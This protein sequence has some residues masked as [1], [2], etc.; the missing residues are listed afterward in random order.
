MCAAVHGRR[1]YRFVWGEGNPNGRIAVILDNPGARE[2]AAGLPYVCWTRQ[3]L[4]RALGEAG[5][6]EAEVYVAFL[7]KCRPMGKYDRIAAAEL[8]LPLL[9]R[10]LA[11]RP[12]LCL[13][14][15]GDT[16]CKAIYGLEASAKS[17]RGTWLEWDRVPLR[18]SYHPLAARRRPNLFPLLVEDLS[19]AMEMTISP[20]T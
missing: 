14:A 7:F 2:D 4:R 17:L 13:I 5:I 10:Q 8:H 11:E 20:P 3:T 19:A 12:R 18:A 1:P 6:P 9:R 16:V 15:L